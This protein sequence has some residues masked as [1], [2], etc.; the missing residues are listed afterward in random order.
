VFNEVATPSSSEAKRL[1]FHSHDPER[2]E[3]DL[4]KLRGLAADPKHR[5]G[6]LMVGHRLLTP[7]LVAGAIRPEEVESFSGF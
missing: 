7:S 1:V 6:Q 2:L 3:A 5:I 4:A